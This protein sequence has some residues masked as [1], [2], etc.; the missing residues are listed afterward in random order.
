MLL[1]KMLYICCEFFFSEKKGVFVVFVESLTW[2]L[3]NLERN[4]MGLST[5]IDLDTLVDTGDFI[6]TVLDRKTE[7]KVARALM[8][9]K[10]DR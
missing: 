8:A 9:N 4:G 6:C 10:T 5:G 3:A 7:S 2:C 1:Q